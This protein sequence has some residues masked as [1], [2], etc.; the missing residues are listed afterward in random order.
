M[1]Y[2]LFLQ[3]IRFAL[4]SGVESAATAFSDYAVVICFVL[5]FA[6]FWAI[7]KELGTFV[8]SCYESA[9]VMNGILKVT[10]CINRPWILDSRIQPSDAA[11]RM[12]TG[13]SFP[14]GHTT[15]VTS[16]SAAIALHTRRVW[17]RVI[18]WLLIPLVMLSRN[19]LGVHT[20]K[21][22]LVGF[23]SS[24]ILVL[25][26]EPVRRWIRQKGY[27]W[28][29][30]LIVVI[31]LAAVGIAYTLLKSYPVS[32]FVDPVAMQ[33]DTIRDISEAVACVLGL[34]LESRF[35]RFSTDNKAT[36]TRVIRIVVGIILMLAAYKG[37][38]KVLP[39]ANK[40]LL[41]CVTHFVL[42]IGGTFLIP[43]L[44]TRFEKN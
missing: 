3:N 37:L 11:K 10:A 43:W 27:R 13:Y 29:Q 39:I 31:V 2:L 6:I 33:R 32:E 26:A 21:D 8:V 25:A 41:S 42:G 9:R 40:T 12:A 16:T 20:A 23:G 35:I 4:G 1:Q 38:D 7:D 15:S 24:L 18:L 30:I 17:L 44:F 5:P 22:V 14:S 34:W 28:G 19:Y 36:R